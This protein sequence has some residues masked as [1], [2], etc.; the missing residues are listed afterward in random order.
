MKF[1]CEILGWRFLCKGEE[2]CPDHGKE[3]AETL[4]QRGSGT[5]PEEHLCYRFTKTNAVVSVYFK[6][7]VSFCQINRS[8]QRLCWKKCHD[9]SFVCIQIRSLIQQ[10]GD[11]DRRLLALEE[12][13]RKVEAK[14]LA[15]VREKTGLAANVTTLD[16]QLV[17]LKKVNEFLKNKVWL[18]VL[19]NFCGRE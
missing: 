8:L 15:A 9:R 1:P 18:V 2:E 5:F 13:L 17:E 4:G 6:C 19:F 7:L 14:L 16:R 10:R 12:D 3:A 11:Q